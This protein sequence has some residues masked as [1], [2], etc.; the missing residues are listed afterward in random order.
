MINYELFSTLDSH[1]LEYLNCL[2]QEITDSD[3]ARSTI[4]NSS[5]YKKLP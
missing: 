3:D 5:F 4:I 2:Q 1:M